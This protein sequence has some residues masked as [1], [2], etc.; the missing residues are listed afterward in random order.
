MNS[1]REMLSILKS[2][3][4]YGYLCSC[5]KMITGNGSTDKGKT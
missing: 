4:F 3:A 2:K 1:S 5:K